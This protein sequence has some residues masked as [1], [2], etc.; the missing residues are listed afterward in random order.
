MTNKL[1]PAEDNP[2]KAAARKDGGFFSAPR[3]SS[4][5]SLYVHVPFCERKC[6]YCAFESAPPRYG[7]FGLYL[8]SLKKELSLR[9]AELGRMTL[10]TCYVGGGTPTVLPPQTWNGL[11]A[12]LEEFFDFAPDAEVTVE[13]NPN[14]LRAEHL[15]AWREWRVTRVSIGVQSFD[16]A[17]LEMMGR[18]HSAAQARGA[19]S[20]ALAAGFSVS[21]DFIFGLP[22]QSLENWARTL[23]EAVRC[24]LSHISL[25]QLS[26]EPGTPWENLPREVMPDGY[27]HYRWAQWYLPRHGYAQ[28]EIANFARP[29]KESRHNLNYWRESEYLGIG[30]GAA[31][32]IGGARIKNSG[33]LREYADALEA[34]KLPISESER[35]G[36]EAR[37]REAAVLALRTAEGIKRAEFAQKFGAASLARVERIMKDFPENLYES[38]ERGIRLTKSGM[39]VA[40]LIWQE[41][42]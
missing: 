17:E 23:R 4:C 11:I 32:C 36:S 34:G 40:N 21:A 30:P 22:H 12:T 14:S 3:A 15:I 37:G 20:A 29:G 1:F 33:L 31:S 39:R 16:G 7:D 24:G 10:D 8:S 38:D 27:A 2:Q 6:N 35:L 13:A 5:R 19:I 9:R 18:L 42:V 25:Y 26:L 41:L 28:Y